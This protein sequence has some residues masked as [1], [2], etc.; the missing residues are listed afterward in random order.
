MCFWMST[1]HESFLPNSGQYQPLVSSNLP[2]PLAD[3]VTRGFVYVR[4]S[5]EL[6]DEVRSI[7]EKAVEKC[8]E[9]DITQWA[10]IKNGIRRE[11]DNFI[12]EKMK[13]KPMILPVIVEV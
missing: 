2:A 8:L 13:K 3:I 7:A 1:A 5:E 10:E 6:I 9:K 11:L 12:Y 4:N